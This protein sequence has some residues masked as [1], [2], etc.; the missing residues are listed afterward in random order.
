MEKNSN[1]K[2]AIDAH[3]LGDHSG[4]NES[5]YYNLINHLSG[6]GVKLIIL[7]QEDYDVKKIQIDCEIVQFKSKNAFVRNFIEIPRIVAKHKIDVL[8]MQYF[9]PLW[10][11]CKVIVTI[12]DISFE[13]FNNIFTKK[14]YFL[15]KTLIPYAA[16]RSDMIF[17]VS[18]YSKRDIIEH[19]HVP[20]QKITVTY[21]G[22]A[23]T[24]FKM[25]GKKTEHSLVTSKY[26][27]HVPYILS[28]GNLQPRKNLKRLIQAYAQLCDQIQTDVCLVI[29]GKKAWMY[30]DLFAEIE[31]SFIKDRIFLTDYVE[32]ADLAV[33]YQ[34]A[35]FFVYPSY[36]EGFGIPVLEAMCSRTAVATSN[37]SS[38][39]EVVGDAG[40]LFDPYDIDDICD[41]MITLYQSQELREKLVLKGLERAKMFTWEKTA[42][43]VMHVYREIYK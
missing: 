13:H 6:D 31:T 22:V 3:A 23:D 1:E 5:Y 18:E 12:H 25:Q 4:G 39:P 35:L 28:V 21:N 42:D 24:Y 34:N 14:D 10:V 43:L 32:E 26:G 19:Y 7:L 2:I 17:T 29:V 16:R 41:K 40:V 27:I 11:P 15:Q 37:C 8:H 9:I 20:E 38:L 30:D 36:F 33:L